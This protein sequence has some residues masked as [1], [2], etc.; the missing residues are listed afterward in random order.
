MGKPSAPQ[1]PDY[2]GAARAQDFSSKVNQYTPYGSLTYEE[3][4]PNGIDPR[5]TSR[6]NLD[7]RVQQTLDTQMNLSNQIGDVASQQVGQVQDQYSKPMPLGS[8]QD[9]SDKAYGAMTSRLD[10]RFQREEDQLR[11]R[12]ANQGLVAGGEAYNNEM[13]NFQQGKNDAYQQA[14]LGAIGTMPQTYQL[15]SSI[16]NQ[17]LNTLNALRTGAQVQNPQFQ[18]QGPGANYLGAAQ[19]QGQGNMQ[20]Y[21]A[22]VGSYNAMA[23]GL[24]GLG[25][26]GIGAYGLMN[27]APAL[28][29]ISDRRLKSNI[30]R[31]GTHKLGIGIY[32]YDLFGERQRGVMA[33]EVETVMP[34]AVI[35]LPI[36]IKAV[37]YGML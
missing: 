24:F 16:Y 4:F 18:A 22:D 3:S 28:A 7:P 21:G 8:V 20:Q 36:G 13:Q 1:Q 11:T 26:A 2:A 29:M 10:P 5:W 23:G 37:N 30:E 15:E 14:T 6:I 27:A 33:D 31:V 32:E 35:T 34:E 19:A 17:P 25:Q 12:L 9:V